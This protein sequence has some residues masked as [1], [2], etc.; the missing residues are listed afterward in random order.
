LRLLLR[1]LRLRGGSLLRVLL[2]R[3]LLRVLLLG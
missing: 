2:R 1:A 3:S